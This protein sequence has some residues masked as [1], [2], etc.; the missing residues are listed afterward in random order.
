MP[1]KS[2]E[3]KKKK[4][5]DPN[6]IKKPPNAFFLYAN[7]RRAAVSREN[8]SLKQQEITKLIAEDWNKLSDKEKEPFTEQAKKY[9]DQ[10][11]TEVQ[12]DDLLEAV[13]EC[14]SSALTNDLKRKREQLMSPQAKKLKL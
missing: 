12:L 14:I 2:V 13:S 6:R 1:P 3:K 9:K 5:K 4:A 11:K 10:H 7:E 8:P